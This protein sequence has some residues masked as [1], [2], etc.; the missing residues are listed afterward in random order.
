[1]Y[2]FPWLYLVKAKMW[3]G[4]CSKMKI[5]KA[6]FS[7]NV[8]LRIKSGIWYFKYSGNDGRFWCLAM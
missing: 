6:G 5:L 1:M 3:E 2:L 4:K 8:S 7:S